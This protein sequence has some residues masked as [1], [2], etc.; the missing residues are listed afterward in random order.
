[1]LKGY[2]NHNVLYMRYKIPSSTTT[3]VRVSRVAKSV[4]SY[5][6]VL[7]ENKLPSFSYLCLS[8]VELPFCLDNFSAVEKSYFEFNTPLHVI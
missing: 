8:E 5:K 6:Q 7:L 2:S 4:L 3:N 1:M